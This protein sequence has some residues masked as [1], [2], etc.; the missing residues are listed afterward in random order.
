MTCEGFARTRLEICPE[1]IEQRLA[2]G[3]GPALH[4]LGGPCTQFDFNQLLN[5]QSPLA[6]LPVL[7]SSSRYR[8]HRL[9][10]TSYLQLT[11]FAM[12]EYWFG[13]GTWGD[14][15]CAR[16]G[17]NC[18]V[19]NSGT[20]YFPPLPTVNFKSVPGVMLSAT[21][22]GSTLLSVSGSP[23]RTLGSALGSPQN[24]QLSGN[25]LAYF[26]R[27]A[28]GW[29]EFDEQSGDWVGIEPNYP[30]SW[31]VTSFDGNT[32]VQTNSSHVQGE[33]HYKIGPAD[34]QTNI[35]DGSGQ[36]YVAALGDTIFVARDSSISTVGSLNIL[37]LIYTLPTGLTTGVWADDVTVWVATTIGT[38]MSNDAGWTWTVLLNEF[39]VGP[40]LFTKPG[41]D[42]IWR[43]S[44]EPFSEAIGFPLRL[45]NGGLLLSPSTGWRSGFEDKTM[46]DAA[47]EILETTTAALSPNRLYLLTNVDGVITL[48]LNAWNSARFAEWCN[49][50]DCKAAYARYCQAFGNIDTGCRTDTPGGPGT[51]ITPSPP[52][53]TPGKGLSTLAI[54]MIVLGV[55]AILIG[56]FVAYL[57][58]KK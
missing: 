16:S 28:A 25:G 53:T 15:L 6:Q 1:D 55:L 45:T 7:F 49:S 24:C 10:Q 57:K 23:D 46:G 38:Y 20:W 58:N 3:L 27:T 47:T 8:S 9:E 2:D 22:S 54:V 11:A 19:F 17:S 26:V 40:G 4:V 18:Y 50:N 14:T 43:N 51:P 35:A 41:S 31:L 37:K 21:Q 29:N 36:V 32:I 34:T 5:A 39:A 44:D 33:F 56:A 30:G 52:S 12:D 48:Y 42:N 13:L